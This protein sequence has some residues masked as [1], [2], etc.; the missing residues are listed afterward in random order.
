MNRSNVFE[1][2]K[3]GHIVGWEMVHASPCTQQD[4]NTTDER[5]HLAQ[6]NSNTVTTIPRKGKAYASHH[7]MMAQQIPLQALVQHSH[8][9]PV[10]NTF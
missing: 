2:G 6:N 9:L 5:S 7:L 4:A 10:N 1:Q 3:P 8:L